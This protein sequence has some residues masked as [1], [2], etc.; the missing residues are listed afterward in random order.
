MFGCD[1]LMGVPLYEK[2]LQETNGLELLLTEWLP[3][4]RQWWEKS[5]SQSEAEQEALEEFRAQA[6]LAD[7][8][9]EVEQKKPI[10]EH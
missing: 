7:L 2:P 8:M 1:G 3:C 4:R 6:G 5:K 10:K 9:T